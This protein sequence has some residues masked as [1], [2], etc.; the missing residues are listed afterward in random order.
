MPGFVKEDAGT[1]ELAIASGARVRR[2]YMD[3]GLGALSYVQLFDAAAIGSV[4]LGTD[5]PLLSIP[6][7]ASSVGYAELD[8]LLESGLVYA[9]T[10]D[11]KN[12]SAV[13]AGFNLSLQYE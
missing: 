6:I 7:A 11:F 13:G 4:N 3:N 10:T 9:V 2:L 5:T 1:K 8:L 12:G